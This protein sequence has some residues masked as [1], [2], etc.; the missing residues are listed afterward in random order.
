MSDLE[1]EPSD[2]EWRGHATLL[3]ADLC[4][5]TAIG[6]THDPEEIDA[7]RRALERLVKQVV[8]RHGGS[9]AQIYGDGILAVFGFPRQREDDPRHAIEAALELR[10]AVRNLRL[11]PADHAS[12]MIECRLHSGLHAGLVFAREGDALNGRYTLSGDAVTTA[13]RLCSVAREDE[14]VVSEAVL[15]GIEGFFA[16][17]PTSESMSLK[18]RKAPVNAY[19]VTGKSGVRNVFEARSRRGLTEFVGRDRELAIL[20][21]VLAASGPERARQLVLRGA[22]GVGKSR[23]LEEF[24]RRLDRSNV[25]ALQGYCERY[26]DI[27]PLQPLLQMLRQLCGIQ[28]NST[29]DEATSLAET[30]LAALGDSI[31]DSTPLLLQLLS[32]RSIG[33]AADTSERAIERAFR[34]V[35]EA[36]MQSSPLLLLIDDWQWADEISRKVLDSLSSECRDRPLSVVLAVRSDEGAAMSSADHVITLQPLDE[37][38]SARVIHALRQQTFDLG[39]TRALHRRSGGNP[40]FLEELC[41]ALPTDAFGDEGALEQSGAPTTLQGVIQARVGL[42]SASDA[43]VLKTA[44]VIGSEFSSSMLQPLCPEADLTVSLARLCQADLIYPSE[45]PGSF[46][47]KHGI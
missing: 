20:Q 12:A 8:Q 15:H 45:V 19:R 5:Y 29:I 46:R 30:R 31:A 39:V 23:L 38:E 24:R 32:L 41:R 26:G 21:D 2:G 4:G 7:L 11:D 42:L 25:Q 1:H 35:F 13:A 10:D 17:Q 47:F 18:G 9:V 44:S 40:L 43:R 16:T 33:H 27:V 14:I 37:N 28:T 34:A 22:A 6:E 3:F 36:L